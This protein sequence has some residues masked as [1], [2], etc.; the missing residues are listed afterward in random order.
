MFE[1]IGLE[2]RFGNE[3]LFQDFTFQLPSKGLIL[4]TGP[5]GSGKTTLLQILQLNQPSKGRLRF[6]GIELSLLNAQQRIDF[7]R[8][9]IA[10][11][12]Q[13]VNLIDHATIQD[14]L[15][16]I[17]HIKGQF[18]RPHIKLAIQQFLQEVSPQQRLMTLS[19]GQ[20]Q[21]FAMLLACMGHSKILLLDEPTTGLDI[22]NR[23][24]IYHLL[25][26]LKLDQ[27]IVM[28]S[29]QALDDGL[30]MDGHLSLPNSQVMKIQMD[31]KRDR[32]LPILKQSP[33]PIIWYF[34]YHQRQR[35]FQKY[36]KR[37][38]FSQ[39]F[40]FATMGVMISLMMFVGKEIM[41]VTETMIGGQYQYVEPLLKNKLI[42]ESTESS[43][44][45][46]ATI[47][48][49][50]E[51]RTYYEESYFEYLKSFHHFYFDIKGFQVVLKDFHL[52]LINLV[53]K[54][55][56]QSSPF[57]SMPMR[58]DE[59][60]LGVQTHHLKFLAQSLNCFP[61]LVSINEALVQSSLAIQL[62]IYVPEWQYRDESTFYLTKIE[63]TGIPTWFHS[64]LDYPKKI[65]ENRLRMPSKGFEEIYENQ[66][67]RVA[68]TTMIQV[69][70][71]GV[72]LKDWHKLETWQH[73]HLQRHPSLGW[74]VFKT[75][76]PRNL[77]LNVNDLPTSFH[78]HSK[79]GYHY[80]PEQKLSGYA[81]PF[82]FN[83]QPEGN[84][85]YLETLKD[86]KEPFAWLDVLPP[87]QTLLGYIL[88]NPGT[89]IKLKTDAVYQNMSMHEIVVSNSLLEFWNLTIGDKV[90]IDHGIY[91]NLNEAGQIEVIKQ[92]SL[93]IIGGIET[94]GHWLYHHPHW[95]T[96]WL[97][98]QAFTPSYLL[99]PEAWIFYE[100]VLTTS[101]F[102]TINPLKEVQESV[103][104]IQSILAISLGIWFLM[105]GIPLIFL[106]YYYSVQTLIADQN[107]IKTLKGYGA[108]WTYVENW[109]G[110]K[111]FVLA[112]EVMIPTLSLLL[113]M[114]YLLK[115]WLGQYF[116]LSI[117]YQFPIETIAIFMLFVLVFYGASITIQLKTLKQ[118]FQNI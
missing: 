67:W 6:D 50:I 10:S 60:V 64:T 110:V 85:N 92:S 90:Y 21:R 2:K 26:L 5:S 61:T 88:A 68:K 104:D 102:K 78:Y 14:H 51:L 16:M 35:K 95:L 22:A 4:L 100:N 98:I 56:S 46:F 29:H 33:W 7:K 76:H 47:P 34:Q 69:K 25:A 3:I 44:P 45:I 19:R 108:P 97:M 31:K 80:Y 72:L 57:S 54:P 107:N 70:D 112:I 24:R 62:K 65:Y 12:Q 82:F 38:H 20:R 18:Q 28:S 73:Y 8:Q 27:L 9:F 53:E 30:K 114:D 118:Y 86:I 116:Y 99:E 109:Y 91:P 48:F 101:E 43:D 59:I 63:L 71:D 87:N 115:A 36:R 94:D 77:Q 84:I 11:V 111:L 32:I 83:S 75:Q 37:L 23:N 103:Q 52:G 79:V 40:V 66:P 55:I 13:D 89:S 17:Q 113:M 15:L 81:Q 41:R 106:F 105:V 93:K 117:A 58:D 74:Q 39:T 1:A 42:L 96:H 49:E